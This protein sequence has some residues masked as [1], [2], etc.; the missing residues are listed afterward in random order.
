[1][2]F[3]RLLGVGF[4]KVASEQKFKGGEAGYEDI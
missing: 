2:Y 4:M 3:S 1:M